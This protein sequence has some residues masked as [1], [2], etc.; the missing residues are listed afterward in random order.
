MELPAFG[1]D[2]D[3]PADLAWLS[4]RYCGEQTRAILAR[5]LPDNG[6]GQKA[7]AAGT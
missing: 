3:E 6:Q 7:R 1:R 4:D 2:I 5:V